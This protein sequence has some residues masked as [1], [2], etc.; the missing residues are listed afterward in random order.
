MRWTVDQ[1]ECLAC[2]TLREIVENG[3]PI[4]LV[5]HDPEDLGWQ[6]LTG[7]AMSMDDAMIES[8]RRMADL[9]S[10][11]LELGHIPPG[12]PATRQSID[13]EWHIEK[14]EE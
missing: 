3:A 9:D 14:T 4:L 2:S 5:V 10:I 1:A 6:F 11:L 13:A 7:A 8:M 12:Y